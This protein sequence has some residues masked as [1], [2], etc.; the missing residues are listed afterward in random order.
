MDRLTPEHVDDLALGAGVLAAGGARPWPAAEPL[1]A[2]LTEHGPVRLVDPGLLHP[3]ALVLPVGVLGA[4]DGRFPGGDGVRH[5]VRA[6][7]ERCGRRCVAVVPLE[8]GGMNALAAPYAAAVLGLPCVDGD[9][10]RL[11][12]S[13]LDLT[14]FTLGGLPAAPAL[15]CDDDGNLV[16]VQAPDN[17]AVHRLVRAAVAEMGGL[18]TIGAYPMAARDCARTVAL[19]SLSYCAGLGGLARALRARAGAA[20]AQRLSSCGVTLLLT[21][22]VVHVARTGPAATS[23][24]TA[25]IESPSESS[26][27]PTRTVRVDFQQGILVVSE[28]GVVSAAVPDLISVVDAD[29]WAPSHTNGLAPGNRVCVLVLAAHERWHGRAGLELAGPR[30]FGYDIDYEPFDPPSADL[31]RPGADYPA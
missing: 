19:G 31:R 22:R 17:R 8:L 6:A 16:V 15:V 13:R 4:P 29:T 24:G 26:S 25:T 2:A 9:G 28:D 11:G 27:G 14:L 23:R 10:S 21:G 7:E 5:V 12:F 1:R 18:A 20:A 3:D 30:R